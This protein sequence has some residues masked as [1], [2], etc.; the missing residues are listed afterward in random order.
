MYRIDDDD[1]DDGIVRLGPTVLHLMILTIPTVRGEGRDG[2]REG[3]REVTYTRVR[4]NAVGLG[5][6]R[7]GFLGGGE[8]AGR[9]SW[10]GG[11][12]S[13]LVRASAGASRAG[14]KHTTCQSS[15]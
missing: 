2:G 3:G 9:G 15:T 6:W 10:V 1:D 11:L 12:A 14:L 7:L 4:D 13:V 8:G 5:S